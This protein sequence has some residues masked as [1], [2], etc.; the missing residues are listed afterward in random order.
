M[1]P[2][3]TSN[4]VFGPNLH[5]LKVGETATFTSPNAVFKW[6][7]ANASVSNRKD[8]CVSEMVPGKRFGV[9]YISSWNASKTGDIGKLEQTYIVTRTA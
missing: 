8:L 9:D 4:S 2:E 7:L 3:H 5:Q 1:S 6:R